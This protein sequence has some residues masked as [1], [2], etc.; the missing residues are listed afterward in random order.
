VVRAAALFELTEAILS[1]GAAPSSPVHLS[2]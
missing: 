1:A 2:L